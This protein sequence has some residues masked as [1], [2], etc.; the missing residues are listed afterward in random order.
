MTD[1]GVWLR[2]SAARSADG[3]CRGNSK[4]GS[5]RFKQFMIV[6]AFICVAAAAV[7]AVLIRTNRFGRKVNPSANAATNPADGDHKQR[8]HCGMHPQV[9]RDEPGICPICHMALTPMKEEGPTTSSNER[10]VLYW[11]DPMLG[12][13][14]ISDKPGKSAM[15]MERVPV[16]AESAGP[17]V[18]IDPTVVQN[19]G[20]RTAEVTRRP[21][22]KT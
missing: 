9:I 6:A 16:Y 5:M 12:P 10:K 17:K 18:P 19:M 7:A 8:W 20:V 15:G 13:S 1:G 4:A 14:S 3:L 2:D 11:W 21:L 22:N